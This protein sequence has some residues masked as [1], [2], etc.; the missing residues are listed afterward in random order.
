MLYVS[1]YNNMGDVQWETPMEPAKRVRKVE[2]GE[3]SGEID[4]EARFVVLFATRPCRVAFVPDGEDIEQAEG[5]AFPLAA[6]VEMSRMIH[7]NTRFRLATFA[8]DDDEAPR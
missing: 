2:I 1:E 6:N 5:H 7:M 3:V 4:R 8:M